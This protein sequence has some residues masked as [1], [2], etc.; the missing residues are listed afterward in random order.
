MTRTVLVPLDGSMHSHAVIDRLDRLFEPG[1]TRLVLL[2]VADPAGS[3]VGSGA[4]QN[5]DPLAVVGSFAPATISAVSKGGWSEKG[6]HAYRKV[7]K[8]LDAYL[9]KQAAPLKGAGFEVETEARFGDPA[10]TIVDYARNNNVDVIAMTTHGRSGIARLVFGSVAAEVLKS[11]V[12]PVLMFR[13]PRLDNHRKE[14]E[15]EK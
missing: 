2:T 7:R 6:E 15:E 8:Q 12:A 1:A 13:P 9:Q 4:A 14:T 5:M 10:E 3:V 11:G